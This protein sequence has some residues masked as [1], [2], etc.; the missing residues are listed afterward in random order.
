MPAEVQKPVPVRRVNIN[1]SLGSHFAL[2]AAI[3]TRSFDCTFVTMTIF[4]LLLILSLL[5]TLYMFYYI[6][7]FEIM[8]IYV[9][10]TSL[11]V[12][13]GSQKLESLTTSQIVVSCS[14]VTGRT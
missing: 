9:N 12:V 5:M 3:S 7:E 4:F 14:P 2:V 6:I 8:I 1:Q 10:I 11:T 13:T